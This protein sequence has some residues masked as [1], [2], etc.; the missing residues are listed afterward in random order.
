MEDTRSFDPSMKICP[1]CKKKFFVMYPGLWGYKRGSKPHNF[2]YYCS[3]KCLRASEK[4]GEEKHMGAKRLLT[5]EQKSHAVWIAISGED[6]RP[7]L[8]ECGSKNPQVTWSMIRTALKETDPETF[9]KLP[10]VI[11]HK[12]RPMIETPEGVIFNGKQYEPMEAPATAAEAMEGMKAAADEFFS[13]CE[14]MGLTLDK[15]PAPTV[16]TMADPPK[17]ITNIDFLPVCG[18]RS[19]VLPDRK[20]LVDSDS[21]EMYLDHDGSWVKLSAG[22]WKVFSREILTALEQLGVEQ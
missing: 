13:K 17:V 5:E 12:K 3:W 21:G 11:G 6:P 19:R 7:Y 8:E 2:T 9:A 18:V 20:F 16:Y 4:K 22:E 10:R 14:E 15:E 1:V